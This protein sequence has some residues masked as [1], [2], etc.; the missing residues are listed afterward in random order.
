MK[1]ESRGLPAKPS[2]VTD[3]DGI[4]ENRRVEIESDMPVILEP[5][6]TTDTVR[7]TNP[8]AVRFR[9][10]SRSKEGTERWKLVATQGARV[11]REFS[12]TGDVPAVIDWGLEREQNSIPRG[13]QPINYQLTLID[14]KGN[15]FNTPQSGLA[16]DQV[17][18]QKKRQEKIADKETNR[19]S[20]ILFDFGKADVGGANKQIVSFIKS[21][22]TP[23]A[24]IAV[25]GYTDRVGEADYNQRLSE[26]RARTTAKSLGITEADV[27][28]VGESVLLYDNNL[29]EGRFYCRVVNVVVEVPVNE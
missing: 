3:P 24:K 18:V 4:V 21:K 19:F 9:A 10:T 17:T 29:P 11:L 26:D 2:T 6:F 15:V 12:G 27:S 1:I 25:T 13:T 7:T 28:G 20:L 14:K 5:V 8:P 22:I 23:D 16:I